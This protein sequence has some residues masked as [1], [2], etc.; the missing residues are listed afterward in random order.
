MYEAIRWGL[1]TIILIFVGG[2]VAYSWT[3]MAAKGYFAARAEHLTSSTKK[4]PS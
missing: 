1:G 2:V 4:E 3:K